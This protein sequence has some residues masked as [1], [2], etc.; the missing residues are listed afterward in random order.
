MIPSL[1]NP[2]MDHEAL[3]AQFPEAKREPERNAPDMDI[4]RQGCRLRTYR[5]P[6]LQACII[7]T[8]CLA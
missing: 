4:P 3:V 7:L 8:G 5:F 2:V 6:R 1:D